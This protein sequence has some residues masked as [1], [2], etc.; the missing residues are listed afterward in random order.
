[1]TDKPRTFEIGLSELEQIVRQL[2]GGNLTLDESIKAFER[3]VLLVRECETKLEEAKTK[4]ERLV[5]SANGELKEE[6]FE[7]KE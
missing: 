6:K 2:E 5:K 1:M 4:V 7:P 3:G